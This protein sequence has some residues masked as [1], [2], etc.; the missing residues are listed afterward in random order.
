MASVRLAETRESDILTNLAVQSEA[1]WGYDLKFMDN[2]KKL[3]KVTEEMIINHP[4]YVLEENEQ[5]IGFYSINRDF[6]KAS[7]EYFYI[8]PSYIGKGYGKVLW[9][10][11]VVQCKQKDISQIEFVTSP[12]AKG[13]YLKMGADEIEE[14]YSIV[15]KERKIPKLVYR[16]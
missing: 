12:Q 14:V 9:K 4:T 16:V 1:Y 3:Y 7:L 8:D 15:M 6:K 11:L 13:F 10:H 2:F 5:I